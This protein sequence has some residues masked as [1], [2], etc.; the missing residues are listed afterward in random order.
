M[1]NSSYIIIEF[2][3]ALCVQEYMISSSL[4]LEALEPISFIICLYKLTY[5]HT[6]ISY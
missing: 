6:C 1:T 5:T 2:Y 4:S 3:I